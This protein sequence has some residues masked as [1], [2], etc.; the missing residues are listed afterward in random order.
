MTDTLLA[1][2]CLRTA[3]GRTLDLDVRRWLAPADDVDQALLERVLAPVL[4][5]GCGPGRH[6]Q[7]LVL[8]GIDALGVELSPTAV[9]LAQRKGV[10]V[11][12]R[13]IFDPVPRGGEWRS[14]LLLDG[15]VGIGGD[16]V[17]LLRRA[18]ELLASR[19]RILVETLPL[20]EQSE[21]LDVRIETSRSAGPWF[22]WAL[23][24]PADLDHLARA[25]GFALTDVWDSGGRHFAQFDR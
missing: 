8:Q 19:A 6:V 1:Q 13:S 20:G 25:S 2:S 22:R 24:S 15:S 21:T 9:D 12:L 18:G 16:P 3:E 17:Q 4:D 7:D 11:I 5:I 14:A 10:P 23:V